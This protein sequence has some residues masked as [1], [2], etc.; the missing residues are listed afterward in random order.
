[1]VYIRAESSSVI[2]QSQNACKEIYGTYL[3][4]S[5]K[6]KIPK[7]L[8]KCKKKNIYIYCIFSVALFLLMNCD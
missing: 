5:V 3:W 4:E 1:M 8:T 7:I 2:N 6:Y